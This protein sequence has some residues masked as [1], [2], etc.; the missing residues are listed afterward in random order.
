MSAAQAVRAL[1]PLAAIVLVPSFGPGGGLGAQG[2]SRCALS[3]GRAGPRVERPDPERE[4][5]I[6]A[7]L[8][9]PVTVTCGDAEM[10]GDSAVWRQVQDEA[11]MIGSVRY[12]DTTRTLEAERLTFIGA[13][14]AVVAEGNVRLVRLANRATLAGPRVTFTRTPFAGARTTATERPRMTLPSGRGAAGGVEASVIDADLAEFVGDEEAFA[15]GSVVLE[16]RDLTATADSARFSDSAGRAVLYGDPVVRGEGYRLAGDSIVAGFEVGLLRAIHSFGD[17]TASGERYELRADQILAR[18]SGDEVETIWAFGEG[19]SLAASAEFVLAGDSIVFAFVEGRADSVTAVGA[20]SAVQVS[21]APSPPGAGAE[22]L[23]A[24][25]SLPVKVREAERPEPAPGAGRDSARAAAVDR[26]GAQT[27]FR[28]QG[29]EEP[30]LSTAVGANW[31]AG[32]TVRARFAPAS[33]DQAPAEARA[34]ADA[35]LELLVATGSARSF[36]AAVRDTA[37]SASPSRNYL[38]GS[39]IEVRFRDGEP[40]ILEGTDA[41]GVFLEPI[42]GEEG[43]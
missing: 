1:V 27:R 14:D 9:G 38:L 8:G 40:T 7:Y 31:I 37:R 29:L 24:A 26:T 12:R 28:R 36:Y 2:V 25:D 41:I 10:T 42:T 33:A 11:V 4:G 21:S 34:A 23:M 17:A 32:D 6:T 43:G 35:Q 3:I 19:R 22:E 39:R 5:A 30:P 15:R 18:I 16:R 20:A 13:R